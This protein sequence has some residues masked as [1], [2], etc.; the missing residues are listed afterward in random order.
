MAS[1]MPKIVVV[2]SMYVDMAIRC[3]YF[4][5]PGEM[6]DGSGFSCVPSGSGLNRAIEVA[7]CGCESYL[8]GKV[9][10]DAFAEMILENLHRNKVNT[11]FVYRVSAMSTGAMVTFVNAQGQNCGCVSHGANRALSSDEVGCAL[12][13]QLIGSCNACLIHGN[14]PSDAIVTVIRT[15]MLH[16]TPVALDVPVPINESGR[17]DIL[18]WPMEYFDVGVLI[19]DLRNSAAR[20]ETGAGMISQLKFVGTELVAKGIANVVIRMGSRGCLIVNR[21]GSVHIPGAGAEWGDH[22]VCGDAFIGALGSSI[23]AGDDLVRAVRF[24]YAAEVISSGRF[25]GSDSLPNK[26]EIIEQLQN[27]SD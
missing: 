14:L 1:K 12:A 24:A 27:Q 10:V 7:L 25:G 17:L 9:G 2:G 18:D 21:E 20:V 15:A 23:G 4:P 13:E 16:R 26:E 3:H 8:M 11:D 5:C 19:P 22:R 6:S